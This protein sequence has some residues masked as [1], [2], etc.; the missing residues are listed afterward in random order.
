MFP[1]KRLVVMAAVL[2]LGGVISAE[3]S[4][5]VSSSDMQQALRAAME[6][7]ETDVKAVDAALAS[8]AARDAAS[9]LG[10]DVDDLRAAVPAL[11]DVELSDLASRARA[12]TSDP[13]AGLNQEVN[14]LLAVFLI[15]A[16]VI[17]VLKAI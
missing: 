4:E 11:S 7:R 13:H 6:R 10:A 16:I 12:L 8:P 15:V 5:L 14:D 9:R 3:S 2:A 1:M 17:L